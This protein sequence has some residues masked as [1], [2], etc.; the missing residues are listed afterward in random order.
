MAALKGQRHC[1]SHSAHTVHQ[2]RAASRRG[3]QHNRVP[4]AAR[5]SSPATTA[6]VM[7]ELS[8]ALADAKRHPNSLQRGMLI[9]RVGLALMKVRELSEV[10]DR[11][12]AI[13]RRLE[14]TERMQ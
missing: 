10:E 12:D 14:A 6:M 3:G 9:A 7:V 8:Q 1:F 2:R 5:I 13:E 4:N 11:L